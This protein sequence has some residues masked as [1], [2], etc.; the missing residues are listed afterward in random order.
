MGVC[1]GILVATGHRYGE[2][3]TEGWMMDQL[4]RVRISRP[5]RVEPKGSDMKRVAS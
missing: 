5:P 4:C 3:G 2:D 1:F